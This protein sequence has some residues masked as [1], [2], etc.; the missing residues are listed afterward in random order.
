M[1][2]TLRRAG[3]A[4][5]AG[6]VAV[7]L[8]YAGGEL[9]MAVILPDPGRFASVEASLDGPW[10]TRLLAGLRPDTV[11]VG[12]P[13]WKTRYKA[14][15]ARVLSESGMPTAFTSDADFSR[16][17]TRL[18]LSLAQVVH[19]GYVA[20]DENGTEAAAATSAVVDAVSQEVG[21]I[22]TVTADRPFL[23]LIHDV[24]TGTPLFIGRVTDPT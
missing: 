5:G 17:T 23:Y 13:R 16:L 15:L 10:L 8:P 4:R 18:R 7:V 19:E 1:R 24:A 11:T 12:L 2:A 9:A 3:Y 20:V 14:M 6:W 21:P 22:R